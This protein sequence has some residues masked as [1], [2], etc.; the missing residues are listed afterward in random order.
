MEFWKEV[1][2]LVLT[3][4]LSQRAACEKYSLG[5]RH[6]KGLPEVP[7]PLYYRGHVYLGHVDIHA[8][9]YER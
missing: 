7:S 2:R 3:N 8:E 6:T 9:G 1:R 4:E 5:W